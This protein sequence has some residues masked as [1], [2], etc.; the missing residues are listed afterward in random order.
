M[1]A[2]AR[3]H[4]E[5]EPLGIDYR[6]QDAKAIGRLWKP[7][8]FDL[9]IGCMSFMDMPELPRVLRAAHLVLRPHGRLVFSIAHPFNTS[10][11]DENPRASALRKGRLVDRYFD[12][13]MG[14]TQWRM[15]RLKRP[16]D[17]PYWHRPMEAWFRLLERS[18]FTVERLS[19][20]RASTA[21][22]RAR[23]LLG[24]TRR[25]PFFLIWEC[26]KRVRGAG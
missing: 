19:E 16:F 1:I 25:F 12:E 22:V 14:V 5:N 17:T 11:V 23:P 15:D 18:G 4:E 24:T 6:R 2:A 7:G 10:E 26:R 8:S 21:Q 20:P 3:Q 9:V 13:R